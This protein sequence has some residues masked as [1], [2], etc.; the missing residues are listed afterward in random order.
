MKYSPGI[1]FSMKKKK[2]TTPDLPTESA[3]SVPTAVAEEA[4]RKG[5]REGGRKQGRGGG[6]EGRRRE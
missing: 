4:G 6:G 1:R 3:V 5:E 2:I